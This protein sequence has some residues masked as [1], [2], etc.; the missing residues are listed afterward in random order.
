MDTSLSPKEKATG[1]DPMSKRMSA[2]QLIKTYLLTTLEQPEDGI[3]D[4]VT[5]IAPD[6]VPHLKTS[7]SNADHFLKSIEPM[8]SQDVENILTFSNQWK[9]F[10]PYFMEYGKKGQWDAVKSGLQIIQKI[11]PTF[12]NHAEAT[13]KELQNFTKLISTDAGSFGADYIKLMS[14][15]TGLP[16]EI[17]A[18]NQKIDA[19]NKVIAFATAEILGG[20]AATLLGGIMVVGG[21]ASEVLTFGAST[22]LVVSGVLV[23]GGGIAL[24]VV[25]SIQIDKASKDISTTH[26]RISGCPQ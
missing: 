20:A 13:S 15:A 24:I 21:L 6:F 14:A 2:G 4:E 23:A 1:T 7:K 17:N 11:I 10:G 9:N 26:S 5:H 3:P 16:A 8:M 25:G 22:A 19:Q 18:L 12:V